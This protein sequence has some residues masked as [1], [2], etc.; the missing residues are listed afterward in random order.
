MESQ[1]MKNEGLNCFVA[2]SEYDFRQLTKGKHVQNDVVRALREMK[3][4]PLEIYSGKQVHGCKIG[5]A[6]GKAGETHM[7]GKVFPETDGLIT[8]KPGIALLVKYADCTPIVLYDPK[9]KVVAAL[10]SGWRGTVQRISQKAITRMVNEFDCKI[11]D[12][13]AYLGPSIDRENYEVGREVYEAFETFTERDTFFIPRG[14]NYHLS[15]SDANEAL[16]REAGIQ[17]THIEV[18]HLST[19]DDARLH[20]ARAEGKEYGLNGL[21]V[22]MDFE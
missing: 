20:S 14:N 1:L 2:G 15:M 18:D 8:D 21:I 19:F 12:I 10:H 17:S 4:E 16:L 6:D 7:F 5:Y 22:M 9:R 13:Y 3:M 11:E